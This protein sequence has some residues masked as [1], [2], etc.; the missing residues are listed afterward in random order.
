MKIF[1]KKLFIFLCL[2]IQSSFAIQESVAIY[3]NAKLIF[4]AIGPKF[5]VPGLAG[6]DPSVSI[7]AMEVTLKD[8][9]ANNPSIPEKVKTSMINAQEALAIAKANYLSC[10]SLV[11]VS[12]KPDSVNTL[13]VQ[14]SQKVKELT[15]NKSLLFIGGHYIYESGSLGGHTASYE[16]IRQTDGKLSFIINNTIKTETHTIDGNRIYQLSYQDLEP[17]DLNKHFW[18]NVIKT[19]YMNPLRGK[20]LMEAFYAFIDEKLFKGSNKTVGRLFKQQEKGV[21]A[22]KSISVWLHSQIAPGERNVNRDNSR[23]LMYVLYKKSLFEN[24]LANFKPNIS[25]PQETIS[26]LTDE[27]K[28]KIHKMNEKSQL[29]R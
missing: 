18:K 26:A 23:E 8:F 10:I 13:A 5:H 14:L 25:L 24:M 27:L 16:V 7:E 29:L 15:E 17:S 4:H 19:N 9:I 21:C 20:F 28:R 1:I 3:N 22:W 6:I 12:K 2:I 11:N